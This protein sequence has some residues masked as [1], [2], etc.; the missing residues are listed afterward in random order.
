MKLL[1]NPSPSCGVGHVLLV[2][3]PVRLLACT[4][5]C[6]DGFPPLVSLLLSSC[7]GAGINTGVN[8]VADLVGQETDG[9]VLGVG[10]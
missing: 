1:G 8:E 2:T 10:W 3:L 7:P 4:S 9:V 6:S 5:F